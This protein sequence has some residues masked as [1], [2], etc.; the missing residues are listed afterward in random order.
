M[1]P[2]DGRAQVMGLLNSGVLTAQGIGVLL[3]GFLAEA[4]GVARTVAVAGAIGALIA[5][6]A[7]ISWSRAL[8]QSPPAAEAEATAA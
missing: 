7:G 1:T 2:P 5:V 8:Q 4:I 6:G 3:A